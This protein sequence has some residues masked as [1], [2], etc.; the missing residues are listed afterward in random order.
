MAERKDV[1]LS[2]TLAE[3]RDTWISMGQMGVD[4]WTKVYTQNSVF[5]V[6]AT[7]VPLVGAILFCSADF[8]DTAF[9]WADWSLYDAT[10]GTIINTAG[11]LHQ[12]LFCVLTQAQ[13]TDLNQ[14]DFDPTFIP[15]QDETQDDAVIITEEDL[16]TILIELG[17]PF[18]NLSELEYSRADILKYSI[19]PALKEYFKW[20]PI[21]TLESHPLTTY[22]FEIP[23][24]DYAYTAHR[25]YV[26]PGYPMNQINNPVHRYFDEVLLAASTRGA[27]ANPSINY[28]RKQGFVD[29]GSFSTYILEKAV[30]QGAINYGA[31]M[32]IKYST[33]NRLLKGYCNKLGMLEIEWASRSNEWVDIPENKQNEVRDLA[34]A[35]TLRNFAMLRM[36]AKSDIPG[37][38][39]YQQFLTR[40]TELETKVIQRWEESAKVTLIRS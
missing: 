11:I 7:G 23:L 19:A 33:Q 30:R 22:T 37:T 36:Q 35:Y 29:Q 10:T 27:F 40:A 8:T 3:R 24:P 13:F 18:I 12:Y 9:N 34:K 1:I 6:Q 26:N 38:I 32:R 28:R 39:D 4:T 25:V 2:Y 16:N 21:I 5:R 14:T 15:F 20:Y 31:R 17:V